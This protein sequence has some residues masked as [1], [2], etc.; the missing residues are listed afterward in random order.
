MGHPQAEL[1][2]VEW[3]ILFDR[4]QTTLRSPPAND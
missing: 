2:N 1:H 3:A 4:R